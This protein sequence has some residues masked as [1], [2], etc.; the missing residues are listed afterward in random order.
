[1]ILNKF[2][3]NATNN[4]IRFSEEKMTYAKMNSIRI[5]KCIEITAL[6]NEFGSE[7]LVNVFSLSLPS[8]EQIKAKDLTIDNVQAV[9]DF[10]NL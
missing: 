6:I 2:I 7:K 8:H 10:Y 4:A 9:L 3:T 1:M 5:E